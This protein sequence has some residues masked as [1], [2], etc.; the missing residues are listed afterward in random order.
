L[1][2][3]REGV[4]AGASARPRG[5]CSTSRAA[6]GGSKIEAEAAADHGSSTDGEA[7][8]GWPTWARMD[9]VRLSEMEMPSWHVCPDASRPE[10]APLSVNSLFGIRIRHPIGVQ[11]CIQRE[12][13]PQRERQFQRGAVSLKHTPCRESQPIKAHA[14][15][16]LARLVRLRLWWR[17]E[18]WLCT[19]RPNPVPNECT[20]PPTQSGRAPSPC[21]ALHQAAR[22]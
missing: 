18:C 4:P 11:V 5:G 7:G 15:S 12:C 16:T 8:C 22:S 3:S 6:S 10:I 20:S 17:S 1:E 9:S 14:N 19:R 2:G 13:S 21:V